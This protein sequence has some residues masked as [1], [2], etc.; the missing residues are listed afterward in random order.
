MNRFLLLVLMSGTVFAAADWRAVELG[1]GQQSTWATMQN[2]VVR[3]TAAFRAAWTQ[4]YP[5]A[6]SRPALPRIDFRKWRV[7]VVAAGTRPTGGYRLALASGRVTRDSAF[8]AVT[9]YT[10]PRGCGVIEQ[11]TSPAVAVATPATPAAFR[12]VVDERPDTVR[13]N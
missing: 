6:A 13:C 3:D 4:L 11:L 1:H 2:V 10:P 8:I 12:V 9:L 5:M 7:I